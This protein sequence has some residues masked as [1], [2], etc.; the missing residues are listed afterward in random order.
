MTRSRLSST[1]PSRRVGQTMSRRE[2]LGQLGIAVG[3]TL[4]SELRLNA[5]EKDRPQ[6]RI[7][8]KYV[9]FGQTELRV[10]RLCQGTAFR[11]NKREADDPNAQRVLHTC[12][13]IGVNFFDSSNAY[14]W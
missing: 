6:V 3:C 2:L 11:K 1:Q 7:N 14:G 4:V 12:L 13:D 9:Q 8:S 10:S 5:Q